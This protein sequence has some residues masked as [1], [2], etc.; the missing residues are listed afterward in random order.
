MSELPTK[1]VTKEELRFLYNDIIF[2]FTEFDYFENNICFIKHLTPFDSAK[3]DQVTLNARR[4]AESMGLNSEK[5]QL[6]FLEKEK[7]WTS[8][9]EAD[10]VELEAT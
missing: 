9:D 2:G 4:K 5:Q 10:F 8:K 6:D 7:L 3:I 1:R